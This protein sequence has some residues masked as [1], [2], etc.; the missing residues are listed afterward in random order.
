MRINLLKP[1][2][3]R[4]NMLKPQKLKISLLKPQTIRIS[5][6]KEKIF[7]GTS[8]I[9]LFFQLKALTVIIF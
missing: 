6:L 1:Q 2:K 5:K 8:M 4:I 3:F 7:S 9:R